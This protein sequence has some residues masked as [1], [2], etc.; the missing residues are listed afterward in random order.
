MLLCGIGAKPVAHLMQ[1]HLLQLEVAK[2]KQ[3]MAS[4]TT[5]TVLNVHQ[6]TPKCATTKIQVKRYEK[7]KRDK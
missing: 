2:I 1:Y 4:N 3:L 7:Y 5:L 6:K